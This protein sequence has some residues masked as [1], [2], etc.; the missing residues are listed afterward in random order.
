M[1]AI[2]HTVL[3][4]LSKYDSTEEITRV[5][6]GFA[7]VHPE[8]E[9][10]KVLK[11]GVIIT[12]LENNQVKK[13][14]STED[15]LIKAGVPHQVFVDGSVVVYTTKKNLANIERRKSIESFISSPALLPSTV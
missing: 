1:V 3:S 15:I 13:Y 11:G 8:G 12:Y 10:I 14:A 5:G 2:R 9:Y 4:N 7:H 6:A